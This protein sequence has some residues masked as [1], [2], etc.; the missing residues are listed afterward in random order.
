MTTNQRLLFILSTHGAKT[1]FL[2]ALC[3]LE[4]R[5]TFALSYKAICTSVLTVSS[6]ES[7]CQGSENEWQRSG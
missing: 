7:E 3:L 4:R 2:I 1:L 6:M 5:N